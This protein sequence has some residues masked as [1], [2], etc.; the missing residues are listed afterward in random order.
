MVA[1][2]G[3]FAFGVLGRSRVFYFARRPGEGGVLVADL[4]SS[5]K[6]KGG[7]SGKVRPYVYILDENKF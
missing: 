1:A 2:D 5:C 3:L 6:T 4:G 7:Q